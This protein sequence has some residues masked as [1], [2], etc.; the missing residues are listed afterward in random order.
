MLAPL[1]EAGSELRRRKPLVLKQF[2]TGFYV[3]RI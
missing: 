2:Y 3:R 1:I